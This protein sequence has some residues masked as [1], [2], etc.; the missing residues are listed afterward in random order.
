M[1]EPLQ[2][3]SHVPFAAGVWDLSERAHK[4]MPS[5][6]LEPLSVGKIWHH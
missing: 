5:L 1:A 2:R 6:E 4:C 3:M